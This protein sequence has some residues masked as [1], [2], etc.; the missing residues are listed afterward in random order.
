MDR[1]E[2]ARRHR[3]CV[4]SIFELAAEFRRYRHL[5]PKGETTNSPAR[6]LVGA[7]NI[8]ESRDDTVPT[9]THQPCRQNATASVLVTVVKPFLDIVRS[10]GLKP[11]A[12]TLEGFLPAGVLA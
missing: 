12:S 2:E 8:A 9:H 11:G 6:A 3:P 5:S 1:T 10:A 4:N 7:G